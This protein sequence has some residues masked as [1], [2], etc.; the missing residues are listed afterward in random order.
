MDKSYFLSHGS[1]L[2]KE[3]HSSDIQQNLGLAR[4]PLADSYS[5]TQALSAVLSGNINSDDPAQSDPLGVQVCVKTK[6]AVFPKRLGSPLC[7]LL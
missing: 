2:N 1:P 4:L 6:A 3:E 5:K 7:I